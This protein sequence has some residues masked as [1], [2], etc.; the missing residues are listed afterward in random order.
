[1]EPFEAKQESMMGSMKPAILG[2][3]LFAAGALMGSFGV[4]AVTAQETPP[5][6]H[7]GISVSKLGVVPEE[8]MKRQ[9]GLE[10]YFLQLRLAT[11]AP[12]GQVARHD[13]KTRPGLVYTLEGTW[14][15][16]RPD[17]EREYPEGTETALVEDAETD[18]WFYN[19]SD[20]PVKVLICDLGLVE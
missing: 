15:E 18:H 7:K 12:G 16:G 8:S 9:T 6:E 4:I 17:G 1:M 19:R 2:S 5:T 14:I 11:V 13:H 10:G 20:S 3:L